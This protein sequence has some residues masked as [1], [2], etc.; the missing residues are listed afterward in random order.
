MEC[1]VEFEYDA[2][3]D[4][5]LTL[6]KGDVITNVSLYEDG[7]MKGVLNGKEGVFP[8]NFVK[9]SWKVLLIF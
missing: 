8:D 3:E 2:N 9:V 6:K 1:V 5:E 7:W 4:D